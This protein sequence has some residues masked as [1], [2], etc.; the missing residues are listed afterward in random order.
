MAIR[1]QLEAEKTKMSLLG[2]T[3]TLGS[4]SGGTIGHAASMKPNRRRERG[5][6]HTTARQRVICWQSSRFEGI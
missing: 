1:Q 5:K 4:T 6:S 2:C 3:P